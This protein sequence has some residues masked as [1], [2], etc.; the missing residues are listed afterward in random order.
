MGAVLSWGWGLILRKSL[1]LQYDMIY[2]FADLWR[3]HIGRDLRVGTEYFRCFSDP[4][5]PP[6]PPLLTPSLTPALA[7]QLP[8]TAG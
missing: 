3:H 4:E 8:L 2:T 7:I 5:C 1:Q 6:I